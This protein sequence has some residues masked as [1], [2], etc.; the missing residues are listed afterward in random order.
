[1]IL[2]FMVGQCTLNVTSK[3]DKIENMVQKS[4]KLDHKFFYDGGA[5]IDYPS[6]DAF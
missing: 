1:M 5:L 2:L 6:L 3:L 4:L